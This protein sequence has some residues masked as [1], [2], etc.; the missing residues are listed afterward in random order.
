MVTNNF[1]TLFLQAILVFATVF[2]LYSCENKPK[3]KDPEEVAEDRNEGK[4]DPATKEKDEEFVMKAAEINW[5]EIQ[6]GQL[7]QQKGTMADVK[8]MGKMM[9]EAHTK[10]MADLSAIAGRHSIA[11]PTSPTKDVQDV[12]QRLSEKTGADFDREYCDR[13]VKGHKDAID[14]FENAANNCED[15]EIKSWASSMLPTLRSHLQ[16]A[17]ACDE[18]IKNM[19]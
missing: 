3:A 10:A 11:I 13:M 5:E 16:Q 14:K 17:E 12:F 1:K 7:A 19:K 15:A 18:K 2:G 4:Q 6:L 8:A 9:E